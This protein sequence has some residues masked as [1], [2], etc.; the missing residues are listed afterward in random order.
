MSVPDFQTLMLPFLRILGDGYAHSFSEMT[1]RLADEFRLTDEERRELL[2]SGRQA[3]FDNRL[4]WASTHLRKAG[5]IENVGRGNYQISERGLQVLEANI[6]HISIR[7][8]LKFP[9]FQ[10]FRTKSRTPD[11]SEDVETSDQDQTPEEALELHYQNLRRSLSLELLERVKSCSPRFFEQLVVDLLVSMGYGGSRQD[12]GQAVGQTG[13]DG[14]DGIIKEDKLGLD[15]VYIQ[16]KRW[17]GSI[18]RPIVQAFA[19]SLEGHRA[20]KGILITT[21]HFTADAKEYVNRIEKKIVLI[22]GELLTQLMI[23]Y[24]VGVSNKAVYT[25]KRIDEDYFS[26]E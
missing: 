22:D 14:I 25:V 3:R 9:E 19:G 1:E 11:H 20:R 4:G 10:E 13:D 21:S 24:G 23:D 7:F 26:G 17:E 8:L 16:A 5:L 18:G 2:P 6:D 12:A 15:A